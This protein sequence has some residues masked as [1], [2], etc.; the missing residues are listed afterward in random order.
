MTIKGVVSFYKD[1][2]NVNNNREATLT[3][4]RKDL[5]TI[6]K[7]PVTTKR[8]KAEATGLLGD[9]WRVIYFAHTKTNII[10]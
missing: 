10:N 3:K 7:S 9:Q 4:I 2:I 6:S 5:E 1:E 8:A